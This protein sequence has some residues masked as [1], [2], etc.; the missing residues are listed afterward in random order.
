MVPTCFAILHSSPYGLRDCRYVLL[1]SMCLIDHFLNHFTSLLLFPL[2]H[3]CDS[4]ESKV[5]IPCIHRSN[6]FIQVAGYLT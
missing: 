1:T 4:G 3:V 6:L 5:F 2:A